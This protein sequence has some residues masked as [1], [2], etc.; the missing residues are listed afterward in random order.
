MVMNHSIA[1]MVTEGRWLINCRSVE[2]EN[3][4]SLF[5]VVGGGGG[6]RS[7]ILASCTF[8]SQFPSPSFVVPASVG[9]FFVVLLILFEQ[10]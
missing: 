8:Y 5:Q 10:G 1:R 4:G 6:W 3:F 9:F 7:E 2:L